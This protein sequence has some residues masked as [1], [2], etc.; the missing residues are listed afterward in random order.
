MYKQGEC[1]KCKS[2]NLHYDTATIQDEHVYY[3]FG[4]KDCGFSGRE[5]YVTQFSGHTDSSGKDIKPDIGEIE[6]WLNY[7]FESSSGLT[8]EFAD[9][10]S[11]F[12][13]YITKQ[14]AKDFTL[15]AWSRGHFEVAGFLQ[16]KKTKKHIYFSTSDV[17][18]F[19]NEWYN[20][21]LIR[22]AKDTKDYTG[23]I[24][25]YCQLPDIAEKSRLLIGGVK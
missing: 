3:P 1:P 12:K 15:E 24:N 16:H 5:W 21:V 13:K 11:A 9:F 23:G 18:Y 7:S 17:R 2:L 6:S 14:T 8:Q 25:N 20:H 10:A 19:P 4:C 22:T